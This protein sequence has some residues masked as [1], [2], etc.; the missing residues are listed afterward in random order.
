MKEG[1]W[2]RA[3]RE[4]NREDKRRRRVDVESEKKRRNRPEFV[5]LGESMSSEFISQNGQTRTE[6]RNMDARG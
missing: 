3:S 4:M 2:W 5:Q 6:E 1:G